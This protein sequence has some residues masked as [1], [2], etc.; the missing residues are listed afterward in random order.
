[1]STLPTRVTYPDVA[2]LG[3]HPGMNS[4]VTWPLITLKD[5]PEIEVVTDPSLQLV[6]WSGVP[7][8]VDGVR[9][10]I[11]VSNYL[12]TLHLASGHA[13]WFRYE[14]VPALAAFPEFAHFTKMS[15]VDW[16]LFRRLRAEVEY[17]PERSRTVLYI[18]SDGPERG[19][20]GP[21]PR[22]SAVRRLLAEAF[23][24]NLYTTWHSPE[25]YFRLAGA[26]NCSV[27]VP[28]S[29]NNI[30]DRAQWQMMGLGVCTISPTLHTTILGDQLVPGLHYLACRDDYSDL[31]HVVK[32][33]L[34][35]PGL[36]AAVGAAAA[37]FFVA[38]G[39]PRPIWE[40]VKRRIG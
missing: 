23:P 19:P 38:R 9:A 13:H 26:C 29:W 4:H 7:L 40:Y 6:G 18:Q 31:I 15:F 17:R 8:L 2:R 28:G 30:L 1:V 22:R 25:V 35:D 12:D 20:L 16:G 24:H 14:F 21:Y 27:H 10:V 3:H 36:A 11:D 32:G 39:T 33:C 5:L 34:S 37:E